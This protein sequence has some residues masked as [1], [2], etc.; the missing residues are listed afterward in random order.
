MRVGIRESATPVLLPLGITRVVR[1]R[2]ETRLVPPDAIEFGHRAGP[3]CDDDRLS[4]TGASP[5]ADDPQ[6]SDSTSPRSSAFDGS[7]RTRPSAVAMT[8]IEI[9][10]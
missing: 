3:V 4:A 10:K 8:G 7:I 9:T 5:L 6:A 2:E 1:T